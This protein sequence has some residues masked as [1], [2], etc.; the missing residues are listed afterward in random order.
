MFTAKRRSKRAGTGAAGAPYVA[1]SKSAPNCS[2]RDGAAA[3]I[4][5]Q[6][7]VLAAHGEAH[8]RSAAS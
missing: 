1:G 5:H 8:R 2:L 4:E 3:G 7:D 6:A